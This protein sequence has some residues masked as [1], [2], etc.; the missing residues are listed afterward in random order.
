MSIFDTF[1]EIK[2]FFV[3]KFAFGGRKYEDYFWSSINCH[4]YFTANFP[5]CLKILTDVIKTTVRE[6]KMFQMQALFKYG[7]LNFQCLFCAQ[8]LECFNFFLMWPKKFICQE[9][10]LYMQA[11]FVF[12]G[13]IL[14]KRKIYL[15]L[16]QFLLSNALYVYLVIGVYDNNRIAY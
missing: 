3:L 15:H 2:L 14:S 5:L 13:S 1:A 9:K 4:L 8:F 7:Y 16:Q 11:Y 10:M 12:R 6:V